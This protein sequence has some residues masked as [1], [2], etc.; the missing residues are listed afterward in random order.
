M[1]NSIY[2]KNLSGYISGSVRMAGRVRKRKF[3]PHVEWSR[4]QGQ[5]LCAKKDQRKSDPS[6][7]G[8]KEADNLRVDKK[9]RAETEA[10]INQRTFIM[11]K[12]LMMTGKKKNLKEAELQRLK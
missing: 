12:S 7:H 1:A 5:T 4:A 3:L 6:Y 11:C 9:R 8:D 10:T 2:N